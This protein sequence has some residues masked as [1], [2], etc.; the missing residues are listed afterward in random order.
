MPIT[1]VPKN[2]ILA[3][4][5]HVYQADTWLTD[6]HADKILMHRKI[7]ER[8]FSLSKGIVMILSTFG[9]VISKI[10]LWKQRLK[11]TFLLQQLIPTATPLLGMYPKGIQSCL[12][13]MCSTMFTAE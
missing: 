10:C 13:D 8:I 1:S 12:E 2:L 6:I 3:S 7:K 9:N 11:L 4:G 5:L